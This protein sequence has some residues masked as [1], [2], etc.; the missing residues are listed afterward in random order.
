MTAPGRTNS[1]HKVPQRKSVKSLRDGR[2]G[3]AGSE[4][5]GG[6]R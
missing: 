4:G 3:E 5:G 6:Q 2:K 1:K